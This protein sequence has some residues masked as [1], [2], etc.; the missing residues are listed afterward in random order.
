MHKAAPLFVGHQKQ[1]AKVSGQFQTGV[2]RTVRVAIRFSSSL[3]AAASGVHFSAKKTIQPSAHWRFASVFI[4]QFT[5]EQL[6]QPGVNTGNLCAVSVVMISPATREHIRT[7]H[8]LNRAVKRRHLLHCPAVFFISTSVVCALVACASCEVP[9]S[10][11][12]RW[13]YRICTAHQ[14]RRLYRIV[15]CPFMNSRHAGCIAVRNTAPANTWP[16]A[17]KTRT[18][19]PLRYRVRWHPAG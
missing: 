8:H 6:R 14:A 10:W 5:G 9:M 11:S 15:P 3:T 2:V 18:T 4:V 1:T 16:R 12:T 17:L 19:S 13:G 7:A